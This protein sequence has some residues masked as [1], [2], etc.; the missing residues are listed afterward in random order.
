LI[1]QKYG[2]TLTQ[3]SNTRSWTRTQKSEL[4]G[5]FHTLQGSPSEVE[6]ESLYDPGSIIGDHSGHN[7]ATESALNNQAFLTKS[8]FSQEKYLRKKHEKFAKEI[9]VLK[10]CMNDFCAS[11]SVEIHGDVLGSL[12]RFSG[13][14]QGS[15]VAVVD[16]GQG[17]VTAAL[18][19]RCCTIDR[20]V[21]G[22][23]TGQQKAQQMFGVDKSE[24]ITLRRN[25]EE[26]ERVYDS[27]ILVHNGTFESGVDSIFRGLKKRLKLGGSIAF[28]CRNIEPLLNLLYELRSA[29]ASDQ[30]TRFVNVQLTEQMCRE[31]EILTDRTHPVMQQ[32]IHLFQ[33]F[34]LSGI[35]VA[36]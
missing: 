11:N 36:C 13:A 18:S 4:Q 29:P 6:C 28:Y 31:I 24:R 34:I 17:I 14:R 1:G 8:D 23:D 25:F 3:S 16:D 22:K 32:S 12:I 5:V 9:T 30:E 21:F 19:Q 35:K 27:L 33:G 20:F 2:S 10:P 15:V 7:R 26:S